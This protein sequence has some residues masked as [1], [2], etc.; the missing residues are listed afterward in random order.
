MDNTASQSI[1][2]VEQ[3]IETR[4]PFEQIKEL[5]MSK[6]IIDSFKAYE[7]RIHKIGSD[8]DA[9]RGNFLSLEAD[10]KRL[11][12]IFAGVQRTHAMDILNIKPDRKEIDSRMDDIQI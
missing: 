9:M 5:L 2:K 6:N 11:D 7:K 4:L 3:L 12:Q 8:F 1:N 10:H